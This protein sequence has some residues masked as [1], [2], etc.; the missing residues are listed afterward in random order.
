MSR[1]LAS[2]IKR[3]VIRYFLF[4]RNFMC[5]V[6]EMTIQSG[7]A[8]VIAVASNGKV[9][10]IE[11]KTTW[12]DFMSE[13]KCI[14][15][16]IEPMSLFDYQHRD[17]KKQKYVKHWIYLRGADDFADKMARYYQR[18]VD[19]QT[20]LWLLPHF[21]YF[22]TPDN[23]LPRVLEALKDTPYGVMDTYGNIRKRAKQLHKNEMP[24]GFY[25][26]IMRR[27]SR[28]NYNVIRTM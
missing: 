16:I 20:R 27:M 26:K 9:Y 4:D 14:R 1:A 22:C 28:S 6:N 21:F 17:N 23:L 11:V 8:D 2:K 24:I 7:I 3:Y 19:K 13:Y 15:E 25:Q 12:A 10:E 5:A 18:L